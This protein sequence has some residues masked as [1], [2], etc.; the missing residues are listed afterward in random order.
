MASREYYTLVASLPALP[1]FEK[2]QRLPIN[3]VRLWQRMGMLEPDDHLIVQ[4][5]IEIVSLQQQPLDRTDRDVIARYNEMAAL[6]SHHQQ[7]REMIENEMNQRS[8]V[9]AL[10]R[11][12]KGM[13]PPRKDENWG[14]GSWLEHIIRNWNHPD[15][16]KGML[17][18]WIPRARVFLENGQAFE[19]E[20]LLSGESW[21]VADSIAQRNPFSFE[22]VLAYLN[23]WAVIKRWLAYDRAAACI[24]FEKLIL[25]VTRGQE[26]LY[27]NR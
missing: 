25:E 23:K 5:L 15:F 9:V 20:R 7:V 2:A 14:V 19:M 17:H 10:R 1:Y 11:R 24:R 18:P 16:R 21:K 6:A 26:Q 12:K 27:E 13:G 8:I 4:K 3:E 22:A